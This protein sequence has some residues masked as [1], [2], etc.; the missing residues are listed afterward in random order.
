MSHSKRKEGVDSGRQSQEGRKRMI[1]F[2]GDRE[3]G[4]TRSRP[5]QKKKEE[6]HQG[7]TLLTG[8]IGK[9]KRRIRRKGRKD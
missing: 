4:R 5:L 1:H 8:E 7:K 2:Q 6:E 9:K 3:K